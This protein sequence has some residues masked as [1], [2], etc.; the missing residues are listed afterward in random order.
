[1]KLHILDLSVSEPGLDVLLEVELLQL[2]EFLGAFSHDLTVY[3]D[4]ISLVEVVNIVS[5][6]G[7]VEFGVSIRIKS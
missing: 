5:E 4:D 1:M 7:L 3:G 2:V 6:R